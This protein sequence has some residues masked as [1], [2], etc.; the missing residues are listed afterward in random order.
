[1]V[2]YWS[3]GIMGFGLLEGWVNGVIALPIKLKMDNIL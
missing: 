3:I 2:E 1:M